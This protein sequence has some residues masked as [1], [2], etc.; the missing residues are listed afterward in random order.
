[1]KARLTVLAS[2]LCLLLVATASVW[3][4]SIPRISKEQLKAKLGDASWKIIDVRTEKDW[5]ASNVKIKGAIREVP[6][7]AASWA[8]KYDKSL[9]YVLY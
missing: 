7:K 3:A 9:N 8:G 4:G 2:A 5:K 1:M 6:N